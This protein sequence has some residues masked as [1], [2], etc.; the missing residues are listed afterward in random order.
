MLMQLKSR[1]WLTL[2]TVALS[3]A[4]LTNCTKPEGASSGGGVIPT[5]SP[6]PTVTPSPGPCA[7]MDANNPNLV[8][9][10]MAGAINFVQIK[11]YP[12]VFGYGVSD[13]ELDI[14]TQSGLINVTTLGGSSPITTQNTI[15]FFNGEALGSSTLHSAYGFTQKS[16][17]ANYTFPSP[18]PSPTA[19]TIASNVNWFTGRVATQD[20]SGTP[21]F[22]PEFKLSAGTYYF[23]DIDAYNATRFRGI[24]IVATPAPLMTH[25]AAPRRLPPVGERGATRWPESRGSASR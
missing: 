1:A 25:R 16:F 6:T 9:V 10:A 5:P 20:S 18:A 12:T 21:C 11:P 13:S 19:T 17:P 7:T 22:S 2:A 24:L 23:G 14:P 4:F 15:Q 3:T 8:V